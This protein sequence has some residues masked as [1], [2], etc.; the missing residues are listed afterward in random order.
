LADLERRNNAAQLFNS[1]QR[2]HIVWLGFEPFFWGGGGG[3]FICKPPSVDRVTGNG[4]RGSISSE[5][6]DF[7][8]PGRPAG[9]R[10]PTARPRLGPSMVVVMSPGTRQDG[11]GGPIIGSLS[12][13]RRSHEAAAK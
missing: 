1:Q 9:A 12:A 8:D 11:G 5:F 6:G 4:E 7:V 2:R 3:F 10:H 13:R